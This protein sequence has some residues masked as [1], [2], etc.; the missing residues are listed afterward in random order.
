MA[1]TFYMFLRAVAIVAGLVCT[2]YGAWLSWEHFG[3]LMGPIAAVVAAVLFIT[4][5]HAA[6]DRLWGHA[7]SMGVLAVLMPTISSAAIL[8]RNADTQASRVHGVASLNL[9]RV[10][11]Q[12]ALDDAKAALKSTEEDKKAECSSGRGL[13]CQNLEKSLAEARKTVEAKRSELVKLGAQ[14][15]ESTMA[16]I[17]GDWS[18][19]F[20]RA[21]AV[22]P[23]IALELAAP[24]LLAFGFAPIPAR[25]RRKQGPAPETVALQ[26]SLDAAKAE[27]DKLAA[28]LKKARG[29]LRKKREPRQPAPPSPA[30]V[31]KARPLKVVAGGK[32]ST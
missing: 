10:Q 9:P 12:A 28:A 6:K 23:A 3:T 17:I 5:E 29:K 16:S 15:T 13:K 32:S 27:N 14:Q 1:R 25:Y 26:A 31:A 2:G 24:A 11:A 21:M 4:C 8:Q 30:Q 20:D 19:V 7:A 22:A 18:T